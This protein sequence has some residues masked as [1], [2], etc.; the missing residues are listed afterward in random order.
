MRHFAAITLLLLVPVL[1]SSQT[2][3]PIK[4]GLTRLLE[5]ELSRFPAKAGIYVKHMSTGEEAGVRP[6]VQFNSASVIKIPVMIIAYQ[7]ADQKKLDLDER[8]TIKK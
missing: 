7:M 4:S 6:D 1:Y 2:A 8:I 3:P 5:G